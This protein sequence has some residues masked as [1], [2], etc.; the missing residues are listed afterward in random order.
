MSGPARTP[1]SLA[2]LCVLDL[3]R[4]WPADI[5]LYQAFAARDGH[6]ILAIGNDRQFGRIAELRASGIVA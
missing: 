5:V 2:G 1:R 6:I 3:T 4:I